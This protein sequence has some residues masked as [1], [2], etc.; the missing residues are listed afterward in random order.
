M[1]K[2]NPEAKKKPENLLKAE[3]I[4]KL[5]FQLQDFQI[6][7]ILINQGKEIFKIMKFNKMF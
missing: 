1:V 3:I 6:R 2:K 4:N 7:C 5:I